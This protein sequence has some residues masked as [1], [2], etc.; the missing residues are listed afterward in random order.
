[1]ECCCRSLP[2]NRRSGKSPCPF[3]GRTL[4][5]CFRGR[6]TDALYNSLYEKW[7]AGDQFEKRFVPKLRAMLHNTIQSVAENEKLRTGI[8][9][10]ARAL[11]GNILE[12]EYLHISSV[13]ADILKKFKDSDLNEFIEAKVHKELE[14]IRINGAVVGLAAGF[15]LYGLIEYLYLPIIS[16]LFSL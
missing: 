3:C 11:G 6:K 14:G 15:A 2:E 10:S 13:T 16:L 12:E 7:A 1:M 8:D 4:S 9:E 5:I